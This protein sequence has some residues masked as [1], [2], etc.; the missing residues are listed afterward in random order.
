MDSVNH[1]ENI[2]CQQRF[3]IIK[4]TTA[5]VLPTW[6]LDESLAQLI[7]VVLGQPA[8]AALTMFLTV[9]TLAVDAITFPVVFTFLENKKADEY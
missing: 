8:Q 1:R 9:Q 4:P 7:A 5:I 3:V 6:N 2:K